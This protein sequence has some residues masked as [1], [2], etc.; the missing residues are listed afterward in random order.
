MKK[1]KVDVED[2]TKITKRVDE[3][4]KSKVIKPSPHD[5]ILNALANLFGIIGREMF[6]SEVLRRLWD[7]IKVN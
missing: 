1:Q 4:P 7:Y 5:I 3:K 6:H 2:E